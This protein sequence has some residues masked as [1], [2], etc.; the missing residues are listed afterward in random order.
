M[1]WRDLRRRIGS[2]P[3]VK[4]LYDLV[5]KGSPYPERWARLERW[6]SLV[7]QQP[8]R[9]GPRLLVVTVL[10]YW[11]DICLATGL[12][13]AAR[14]RLVDLVWLP[15]VTYSARRPVLTRIHDVLAR[16]FKNPAGPRGFSITNL[17]K[18]APVPLPLELERQVEQ[19]SLI[20]TAYVARRQTVDVEGNPVHRSI[21]QHRMERN[22]R[23]AGAL[24][25]LIDSGR[26]DAI[27]TPH[28]NLMEFGVARR[29][30]QHCG[31]VSI[32]FEFWEQHQTIVAAVGDPCVMLDSHT[33]SV[34]ERDAPHQFTPERRQR[35]ESL[36]QLRKGTDWPGF[37]VA[38]QRVQS[39]D[40]NKLFDRLG[41]DPQ[42]PVVLMC[43]NVAWDNLHWR[44]ERVPFRTMME[45]VR[46]TVRFFLDRYEIQL[47]IRAHPSE[48]LFGTEE[49]VGEAVADLV[50]DLPPHIKVILPDDPVNTYDLME[51]ASLGLVYVST[52][53]LEMLMRGIPVVCG[54]PAHYARKGFTEDVGD[55]GEYFA[56]LERR[57]L[58]G[59][60]ERLTRREQELAWCYMDVYLFNWTRPFPWSIET[61]E[62]D[63]AA[64]PPHRVLSQEGEDR[65]G[66][67][68]DML[69]GRT[70]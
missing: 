60:D 33:Q 45:W 14:G 12:C 57:L 40:V 59:L 6:S 13:I 66:E 42:R 25:H 2:K 44:S 27:L 58:E 11:V 24:L 63:L 56:A 65:F 34:W 41:L 10:P 67:T 28:G 69:S 35:I 62:E 61:F 7:A 31:L 26:Y 19:Q 20:D 70:L 49:S 36:I 39:E 46:E 17:R 54:G 29:V 4:Q 47:V 51:I 5:T 55:V 38:Y 16:W 1:T 53:G 43:P 68:F 52:T 9:G 15:Y 23:A 18:I 3:G 48:G 64:W 21:Y 22:R 50:P 37:T 32:T 30:A 8:E